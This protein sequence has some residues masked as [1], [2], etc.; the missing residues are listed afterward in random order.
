[1]QIAAEYSEPR[2]VANVDPESSTEESTDEQ[3]EHIEHTEASLGKLKKAELIEI[4]KSMG[5]STSGT[6]SD[7]TTAILNG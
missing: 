6:K 3:T 2:N 5:V 7:L 4:A 1:A